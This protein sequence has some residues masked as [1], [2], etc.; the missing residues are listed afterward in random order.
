[1]KG[2]LRLEK[3]DNIFLFFQLLKLIFKKIKRKNKFFEQKL[4]FC[5]N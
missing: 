2:K 5:E 3:E 4:F 1:M